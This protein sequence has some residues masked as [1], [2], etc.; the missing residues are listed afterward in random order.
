MPFDGDNLID[1]LTQVT[2]KDPVP[3]SSYRPEVGEAF[4]IFIA[5]AL[6]KERDQRFKSARAMREGLLEAAA[7]VTHRFLEAGNTEKVRTLSRVVRQN[8]KSAV[9]ERAT[10]SMAPVG[11]AATRSDSTHNGATR[12]N[13]Q[14]VRSE[15][16]SFEQNSGT[17]PAFVA[18]PHIGSERSTP[19][20]PAS[21]ARELPRT[22]ENLAP[23]SKNVQER[24]QRNIAA[25]VVLTVLALVA[26][27]ILFYKAGRE[28]SPLAA[29]TQQAENAVD[30]VSQTASAKAQA[31]KVATAVEEND[32]DK[33]VAANLE[34]D[35]VKTDTEET[36]ELVHITLH[37]VPKPVRIYANGKRVPNASIERLGKSDSVRLTL[38]PREDEY[39]LVL[40]NAQ[41]RRFRIDVPGS[42]DHQVTV[43]LRKVRKVKKTTVQSDSK[44]ITHDP[45]K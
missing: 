31:E 35:E 45:Y 44:V 33:N 15:D 3:L 8:A 16:S 21:A 1:L 24:R 29:R 18:P 40:K 34:A 17:E 22:R 41:G 13:V 7:E 38:E 39:R 32:R 4:D 23:V 28:A 42:G 14:T 37:K 11:S 2:S 36:K 25:M 12:N 9:V 43:G 6:A 26:V 20:P 5:K 10:G 27:G 19:P 30:S